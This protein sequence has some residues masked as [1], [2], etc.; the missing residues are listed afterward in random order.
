M[1]DVTWFLIG[2]VVLAIPAMLVLQHAAYRT[3]VHDGWRTNRY[4]RDPLWNRQ[5]E[6]LRSCGEDVKDA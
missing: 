3:G 2:V 6:I 4:P 1:I 5:R